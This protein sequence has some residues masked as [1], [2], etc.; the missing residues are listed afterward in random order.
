MESEKKPLFSA[1]TIDFLIENCYQNSREWFWEHHKEY[2]DRVLHPMRALADRLSDA[3]EAID[4]AIMTDPR[5][6][7]SHINRDLRYS[8]N[9]ALYRD[10]MW[11]GFKRDKKSHPHYP[12]IFFGI[13][14]DGICVGCG[15]WQ[16]EPDAMATLRRS[17]LDDTPEFCAAERWFTSQNRF[18]ADGRLYKRSKFPDE[19]ESR[20]FWLDRRELSF[21]RR[22][23]DFEEV[24]SA[25]LPDIIERDMLQLQYAYRWLLK[26]AETAN[27]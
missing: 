16:M 8:A 20:R 12:E 26:A 19:P 24:Y 5:S 25:N 15:C 6:V 17:V 22:C 13:M 2:E 1:E 18:S 7:V 9:Q 3:A 4:P 27:H 21:I 23:S 11:L 10:Y 14:P